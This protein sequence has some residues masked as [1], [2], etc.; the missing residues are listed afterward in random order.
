M[1]ACVPVLLP[2]TA[3]LLLLLLL[4]DLPPQQR[5]VQADPTEPH[6]VGVVQPRQQGSLCSR[7]PPATAITFS[8]LFTVQPSPNQLTY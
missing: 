5:R 6:Q 2:A 3:R 1:H 7:Q 4:P 8:C